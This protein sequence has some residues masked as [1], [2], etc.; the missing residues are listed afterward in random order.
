M[1]CCGCCSASA[2]DAEEALNQVKEESPEILIDGEEFKFAFAYARDQIYFTS[3]RILVKDKQGIFGGS[4]MWKSIPYTSIKCFYVQTAGSLDADVELGFWASGISNGEFD[5]YSMMASPATEISFKK[6]GGVDLFALQNLLNQKIFNPSSTPVEVPPQPEGMDDGEKLSNFVDLL[7]G[8]ARAIDPKV[9]EEQLRVDPPILLP[10]EVVDM[11]FRCGRD[12]TCFT[13]RRLLRIDVQGITG[14]KVNYK[15]YLWSSIRAF[16]VE[17]PG[18]FLDRDC[19]IKL[20]NSISHIDEQSFGMDLRNSS[21]DIMAVQRYLSDMLLGQDTAPPSDQADSRE[22]QE[23]SGGGWK[24][25]LAGDSRQVDPAEANRKFHEEIPLLQGCETCEMAFKSARDMILFTT[26]RIVMVD[27][28]GL[29]GAKVE[30]KSFPWSTIQAFGLQSAGAFLDKDSEM[31]IWTDIYYSYST[32]EEEYEEGE[33]TKTRTFYIP[34]PGQSYFSVDFDKSKVD[35]PAVGRYLASRCAVLG[36]QTSM[37]PTPFPTD[38]GEPW[39]IEKFISWL[40][41]DYRQCD[42]DELDAQLHGDCSML[43]PDEK[44]QMGFVCGR[45]TVIMTTHRVMKIDKQGF[46]GRKVLYLSLPWTKIKSYEVESAGTFDLDAKMGVVIKSPWYNKEIGAGMEIDFSKGRADILA[47]NQFIS[48]QVIGSADGAS[49]VTR[50]VL[51]AQGEG[52]VGQF[53]SWIGDDYKQISADEATEK[54]TSDPAMLLPDEMVDLA[55]KC[56][57]DMIVYT[58]KRYMRIDT[59]GWTGQKVN[60]KSLPY[61]AMACFSATGAAQHPF[62]RDCEIKMLADVGDWGLDVKKD[63][64]DIMAAYTIMNKKVI[65]SK[66][67]M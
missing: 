14:K 39:M 54:L 31:M 52:L 28:Q 20:W 4:V 32:D 66:L 56:G 36:S 8:D 46:T 19:E 53:L 11:A 59:Q 22:G 12:T 30:Y 34:E 50:E 67:G 29:T 10:D 63:Q 65:L 55:F 3:F 49:S 37:P 61:K 42:P 23:D 41:D 51:P 27:V 7:G 35:L 64:G 5:R 18:M 58:T 24:A 25:W 9:V 57:R 2:I 13:N 47:V 17:T 45:D 15:T 26:K 21:V 40:G 33:E 6:G 1:G 62:D 44:V 60:Y 43:L 48:A 38:T 16:A